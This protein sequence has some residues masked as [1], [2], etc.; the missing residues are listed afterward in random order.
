ML[1]PSLKAQSEQRIGGA[2]PPRLLER[3]VINLRRC[4]W[5]DTGF[6]RCGDGAMTSSARPG[7]AACQPGRPPGDSMRTRSTC[8]LASPTG[9]APPEW[10][11]ATCSDFDPDGRRAVSP[12]PVTEAVSVPVTGSPGR[13]GDLGTP[14]PV[15]SRGVLVRPQA[16]SERCSGLADPAMWRQAEDR[17]VARP[18]R[19]Q[20]QSVAGSVCGW[21]SLRSAVARLPCPG[22][23]TS[24]WRWRSTARCPSSSG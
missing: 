2:D 6:Q 18:G 9:P 20:A 10:P 23:G 22:S 5:P 21:L 1:L 16:R 14:C 24:R 19:P 11:C 7:G 12:R 4:P 3:N 8:S 15:T 13:S 17:T